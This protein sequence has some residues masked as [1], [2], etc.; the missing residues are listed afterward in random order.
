MENIPNYIIVIF[1]LTLGLTFILFLS[2]AKYKMQVAVIGLC[3]LAL[4]GILSFKGFF[5][6][7]ISFPP[8]LMLAMIP[9]I[10]FII[11]LLITKRGRAFVDDL[12]LRKLTLLHV[13]RIPVEIILFLLATNK[14]IPELMTFAGRN[15]DII[16]GLTTPV[17]YFICFKN[18]ELR[19]RQLLLIWNF[20]CLG[21]L[22]NIVV[23]ALL[24]APFPFQQFAFDQP[25][26]AL[27]YF[28]FTWLPVFIV[29]IVLLSHLVAIRQLLKKSFIYKPGL[30]QAVR[31][32]TNLK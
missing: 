30:A 1:L 15:F 27:L 31:V 14:L 25:D 8:G 24:S 20:I 26:I 11:L 23:N 32:S 4:T 17:I 6:D 18:S 28:P 22:L 9:A 21:L 7:K 2:A 16:S 19:N 29:I 3:W 5:H 13:I 12:D 10:V